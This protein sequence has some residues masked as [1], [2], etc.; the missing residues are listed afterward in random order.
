[1]KILLKCDSQALGPLSL[2]QTVT[3]TQTPCPLERDVLHGRPHR[4]NHRPIQFTW[5]PVSIIDQVLL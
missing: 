1:M 2:S 3:P 4:C 5:Y